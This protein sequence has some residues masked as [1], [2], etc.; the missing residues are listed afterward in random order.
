MNRRDFVA[1]VAALATTSAYPSLV[2]MP[3]QYHGFPASELMS[4]PYAETTPIAQYHWAP[5][6]AY[7]AFQDM[8]FGIRIHW[9]IYSIWHRGAESWPFLPMSFKD[10][11]TYNNLYRTW[12]PAG[13]DADAWI[14]AFKESGMKMFAF[15]TKHH[16]GFSMFD[17]GTR[18]KSRANWTA[19]GGPK[20]EPCD[21]AYSIMET[22][23]RRDIVK[24]LCDAA[25]KREIKIDFYFS[26]PDWYDADFRPYVA[27]PLQIPSSIQWM[28]PRDV[29]FTRQRLGNHAVIV[30]DPTDAEVKRMMERHRAQLVELL[31]NYGKIDMMC[32]DMWLG[33]RVWPELRKTV[34]KLRQIQ[35]DVMLR[36]RGIGNYGD[37]YTPERVVPGSKEASDK[38]WFTI[39]PLGTDFSYDPDAANYKGTEWIVRNLADAVAKGGGLQ[40]GV[41]P[42]ARRRVPPRG[43]PPN[44]RR[45]NVAQGERRSH[46]RDPCPRRHALVGGRERSLHAVQGPAICLRDPDRMA[47]KAGCTEGGATGTRLKGKSIRLERGVVMEVRFCQGNNDRL[48]RESAT[49]G[50]QTL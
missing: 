32:L 43:D 13:F 46:L 33:P 16:E 1:S 17:T 34:L 47:R 23:F 42:N 50:Q 29:G 21:L 31:T 28:T 41:G 8:K 49:T 14:D 22:P 19:A 44:E 7:E 20:I 45:G 2:Q 12:N 36:D 24:E 37:Y 48:P 38:P 25:H 40:I 5:A 6:S 39:Y 26:H 10:R 18:V 15:T 9:G 3:E 4:E 35:P 30:P 11:Q 27:H